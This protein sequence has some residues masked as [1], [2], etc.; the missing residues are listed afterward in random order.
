MFRHGLRKSKENGNGK[1]HEICVLD[2]IAARIA[3]LEK[4]VPA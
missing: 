4:Y 1:E 2:P 3:F